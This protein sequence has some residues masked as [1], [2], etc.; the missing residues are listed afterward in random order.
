MKTLIGE[1]D[2]FQLEPFAYPW[3]W[4]M[5]REC[6]HNTWTP[7]EI[8]VASDV[9]TY[10]DPRT[11]PEARFLFEAV[12]A[13]LTTFDIQRG[14]DAAE[15]FLVLLQPAEIK[16]FLKRLIWEEALHTRSYRFIIENL[17]VP[18]TIYDRWHDVP[19]MKARVEYA[20]GLSDPLLQIVRAQL[21]PERPFRWDLA[22]KQTM[23]RGLIFWFLIFE[24]VWFWINL[25]GPI[26]N[27]ARHGMFLGAAEQFQYITRDESQHI[28]FGVEMVRSFIGE[29]SEAWTPEFKR[30]IQ[31]MFEHCVDLEG[32]YAEY[33]HSA[34]PTVGYSVLDHVETS[35][36][37][38]NMRARS[39]GLAEPFPGAK[40]RFPWMSEMMD[41]KKEK[42][43]FETRVTDYR[44]GG[45]LGDWGDDTGMPDSVMPLSSK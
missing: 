23:L 40:H 2:S 44:T 8:Q 32:Q 12:L 1:C 34:G 26:Q 42:N 39:I 27:L 10:K 15:T 22:A 43:F 19:A 4:D 29:N 16:H 28:R 35:R 6:E 24:G 37:F 20:Q 13:Q 45:S 33:C 25:M 9:V 3:A 7:E 14:D 21:N 30:E 38:S 31:Q 41:L 5:S 18:L 36:F 17:G 11:P